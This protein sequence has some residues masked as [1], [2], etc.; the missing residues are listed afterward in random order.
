MLMTFAAFDDVVADDSIVEK[1]L[2]YS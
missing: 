1:A 2:I